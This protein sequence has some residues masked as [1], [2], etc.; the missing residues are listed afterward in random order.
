MEVKILVNSDKDIGENLKLATALA[1]ENKFKESIELLKITLEKIF[2]SGISYPSSTHVKILPYMQKAGQYIEIES[3]CENYLIPNGQ[4]KVKSSFSHKCLEI[5]QAFCS[6]HVSD[7]Y[8]KMAL[9]AKRE[10]A[11]SDESK[12]EEFSK[13]YRAEYEELIEQGEKV[14]KEKRYKRLINRHGRGSK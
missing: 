4:E 10:K 9:C 8:N 7:I 14:E 3:F 2:L 12:F 5:Q 6:L 11:I 13:K 1:K